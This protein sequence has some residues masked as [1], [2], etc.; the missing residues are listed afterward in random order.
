MEVREKAE[1][2]LEQTQLCL[3]KKDYIRAE[4]VSNKIAPKS[5]QDADLQ[6]LKQQYYNLMIEFYLHHSRFLDACKAYIQLSDIKD[7]K[8]DEA[9]WSDAFIKS[10]LFATLSPFDSEVSDILHRLKTEKKI[11]QLPQSK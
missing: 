1:F 10:V 2:L 6:D 8:A 5:L 11:E 3:L 4:I 9:K 7:V